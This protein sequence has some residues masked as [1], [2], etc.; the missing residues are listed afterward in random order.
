MTTLIIKTTPPLCHEWQMVRV[1][2]RHFV[3]TGWASISIILIIGRINTVGP[4]TLICKGHRSGRCGVIAHLSLASSNTANTGVHLTQ[5][6]TESVEVS[7]HVLKL[8]HDVLECHFARRRGGSGCRWSRR[9]GR[10][11]RTRP[12]RLKLHLASFN[13]SVVNDTHN[14]EVVGLGKRNKKMA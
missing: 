8:R 2:S 5:L 7:I 12:P 14:G 6:I 4:I 1:S 13:N 10:S 3:I 11:C 9:S